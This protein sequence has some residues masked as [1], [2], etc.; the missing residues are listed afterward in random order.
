MYKDSRQYLDRYKEG[1]KEFSPIAIIRGRDG[2]IKSKD[3]HFG[4]YYYKIKKTGI[5][6][7]LNSPGYID[8]KERFD[9]NNLAS[10]EKQI[11]IQNLERLNKRKSE[12]M[13]NWNDIIDFQQ[14][15]SEVKESLGQIKRTKNLYEYEN[16]IIERNKL[17]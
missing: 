7:D 14:K 15:V 8:N 1:I 17:Q 13:D 12:I 10:N 3:S 6:S 16:R 4:G 2:K 5:S 9:R 11:Q